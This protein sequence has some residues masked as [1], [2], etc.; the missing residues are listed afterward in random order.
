MARQIEKAAMHALRRTELLGTSA[1]KL[2]IE[3]PVAG[4]ER[5]IVYQV[6]TDGAAELRFEDTVVLKPEAPVDLS[7]SYPGLGVPPAAAFSVRGEGHAII[8]YRRIKQGSR[9]NE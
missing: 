5:L 1:G 2:P 8:T 9:D 6:I 4:D 7:F 3:I